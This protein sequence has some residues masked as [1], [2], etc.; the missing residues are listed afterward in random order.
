MSRRQDFTGSHQDYDGAALAL[1]HVVRHA[2]LSEQRDISGLTI[3]RSA[4]LASTIIFVRRKHGHSPPNGSGH[5][6]VRQPIVGPGADPTD[7]GPCVG[8]SDG[9][10]DDGSRHAHQPLPSEIKASARRR[11]VSR[12]AMVRARS[13]VPSFNQTLRDER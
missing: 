4:K 3:C 12:A 2:R 8:S 11:P 7:C 5:T 10:V 13:G 9:A 6:P 1:V